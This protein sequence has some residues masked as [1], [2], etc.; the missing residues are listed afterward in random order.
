MAQQPQRIQD[1]R[2]VAPAR[3]EIGDFV[4]RLDAIKFQHLI[5][6]ADRV[7]RPLGLR[8]FGIGKDRLVILGRRGRRQRAGFRGK[9]NNPDRSLAIERR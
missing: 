2:V 8:P 9:G 3:H 7:E 5:G 4:A 6:L 1:G